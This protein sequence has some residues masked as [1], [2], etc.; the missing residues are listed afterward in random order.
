MDASC[1][2]CDMCRSTAPEFFRRDDNIGYSTV[3]RQ[4]ATAEEIKQA[5]AARLGCPTE[6]IGN[7][8]TSS[9]GGE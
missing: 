1:I 9:L 7:D 8:G 6:S 2:D 3:Y 4:P 5:E